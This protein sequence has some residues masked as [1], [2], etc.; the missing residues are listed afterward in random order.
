MKFLRTCGV[1]ALAIALI[2]A[3]SPAPLPTEKPVDLAHLVPTATKDLF[4]RFG[5]PDAGY[6]SPIDAAEI[7]VETTPGAIV[8]LAVDGQTIPATHI[9]KLVVDRKTN[10]ASFHFYGVA[11]RPGPNALHARAIGADGLIGAS[12]ERT[13]YGPDQ[14]ATIAL[15][16]VQHLVADGASQV[17]INVTVTDRYGHPAA[18]SERV[19]V[20]LLRGDA[21][22]VPD[23]IA[24]PAPGPNPHRSPD[25]NDSPDSENRVLESTLPVGG[26]FPI[27]VQ[28]GT[29]AGP[30]EVE[31]RV[32]NAYAHQTFYIEPFVRA[33]FVN[34]LVSLGAGSVPEAID[35]NG[36]YDA[37]GSRK[38]RL[39]LFASGSVGGSLLTLAYESQNRLAP[40]SSFGSF[41]EDP[42]SRPYLTYGD[43]SHV[44]SSYLSND[45][46][47]AR[48]DHG[49]SS[50]MWGQYNEQLGP[51]DL[52]SYSQLLSGARGVLSLGRDG[53]TTISAFTARNDQ[54]FV[55][56]LISLQG[57]AT[58]PQSLEPNIVVGSDQ[59]S[60][61]ALDRRTGLEI[62][63]T[64]LLRNVDYTIDYSTG[65]IRFIN[66]PLPYD[67]DFNPQELSVRYEYQGP[68]VRSRTTGG[69]VRVALSRDA[70]TS[71]IAS[72]FND[73]QGSANLSVAAQSF[74]RRWSGGGLTIS[75]ATSSGALANQ[76][77]AQQVAG[78]AVP[79]TGTAFSA[80]LTQRGANDALALS[81]QATSAGYDDPFGGFS[82]PGVSAYR[83][84][85]KH[86]VL[87]H[88]LFELEYDG[89]HQ[90]GI[91]PSSTQ[92]D[93][94]ARFT[95]SLGR[96]FSAGVA[97]LHHDQHV[98]AIVPT[99]ATTLG[100]APAL[101]TTA[102]TQA[103]ATL[104]YRSQRRVGATLLERMTLSGSDYGSTQPSQTMAEVDYDLTRR[105]RLFAR[106]L[107]SRTPS[108]TFANTTSNLGING[109][110]THAFQAGFE[111]AISPATTLSSSYIV[112]QTGNGVNVYDALGA[113]E[114]V[115]LSKRLTGELQLQGARAIGAGAQ[116]FTL[117]SLQLTYAEP[118]NALRASLGYQMRAGGGGGSTLNAG[119]AGHLSSNLGAVGFITRAWGNGANAVDDRLSVAYRPLGNDRFVGL[120][121]YTRT[122][123]ASQT[124]TSSGVYSLDAIYR[125]TERT[126]LAGRFAYKTDAAA[127]VPIDSMLYA[128]RVR[129]YLGTRYDIGGEV[130]TMF[131]P[132]ALGA[133]STSLAL[134]AGASLGSQTRLAV[135]YNLAGSVD[136]TLTSTPAR[137]G[138]YV[139]VTSLV[140]RIFG[141]GKE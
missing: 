40:V 15:G 31:V 92:S 120:F 100:G 127:G 52:G 58:L 91:G 5:A 82:S 59:L 8:E 10:V 43:A 131:V 9:G 23:A 97:L 67:A 121:G 71:L 20:R 28:P 83:G 75:R 135:G 88:G 13:I 103:E 41:Q 53:R 132:G 19:Q 93:F 94:A 141:W 63:E 50:L 115:R 101:S 137:R 72:Y 14:A 106:E 108:A 24:T 136:P 66:I 126:E 96:F 68:G 18:P 39:G 1:L 62:G 112:N 69:D 55:S 27:R 80:A 84:S 114:H 33:A 87:A 60:V 118:G 54:A 48:I 25:V 78:N 70:G 21:T 65:I 90:S 98:S 42:N 12:V 49:R 110:S 125:P 30:L 56:Q 73:V 29:V 77:N 133:R 105:G 116:G 95:R 11:L 37:G 109:S 45:H 34:G 16:V 7:V 130:R 2:A 123:G 139:T 44:Q 35:G 124:G 113:Q 61:I 122:N 102:Q 119:L 3:G 85:W 128:V 38:E 17:P 117:G 76:S 107:W 4:A 89:Q 26:Y 22:I 86:G 74:E 138:F 104:A 134:E 47:Y 36:T 64:P 81:Y 32:G 140:D 57:L 79:G 129:R 6:A 51:S 111:E 46:L 99:G